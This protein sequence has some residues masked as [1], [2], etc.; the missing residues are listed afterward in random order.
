MAGPAATIAVAIIGNADKLN[1]ALNEGSAKVEGF[2]GS[3]GGL[4]GVLKGAAIV[5]G[6][7]AVGAAV[8]DLT[9]AAADDAAEQARLE[10]AIAAAGA[11]TGDWA[12]QI[13]AAIAAGQSLAFTDTQIRDAM[14]PLVGVTGDV[15]QAS[16]LLATAQDI[17]RLKGVDL[18]TAAEAVAKAQ[19]GSATALGRLVGISTQGLTATE[20]LTEAQRRASGQ[21]DTYASSTSGGLERMSIMFSEVGETVG[22]AFLPVLE[23]ILPVLIPIIEQFAELVKDLLPVLIPL[24]K[25]AVIPLKILANVISSVLDV[26]GPL[27]DMLGDAIDTIGD[28]I[29]SAGGAKGAAAGAGA[30][31]VGA[32]APVFVTVNTGAD[33]DAV[34]RAVRRYAAAN[35]GQM[36]QLRAWG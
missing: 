13:D 36:G 20:V 30:F 17:A 8:V 33:P 18:A 9:K 5:G 4:G 11:A 29:G 34:I 10:Q 21:A 6:V 7:T 2:A 12:G 26:L 32:A 25:L 15:A 23:E 24:L 27:I 19:D 16:D 31:G 1:A 3:L 22:S 14:V 35:G 28:F